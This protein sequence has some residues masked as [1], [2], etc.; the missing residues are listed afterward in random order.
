MFFIRIVFLFFCCFS[1]TVDADQASLEYK[2]KA[3]YLYNFTKFISWPEKQSETFNICILGQDPFGKILDPL[4]KRTVLGKPIRLYRSQSIKQLQSCH[5]LYFD[6]R[7]IHH[8]REFNYSLSGVLTISSL[9]GTLTGS[10]HP[11]F[12]KYDGMI[13]FVIRDGRIKLQINQQVMKQNRL[14]ISAKLMEIAELVV[15]EGDGNGNE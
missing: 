8:L 3:G 1:A 7:E 12:A 9:D 10:H 5:I 14:K 13:G 2:V 4:E 11:F 6:Q 15:V